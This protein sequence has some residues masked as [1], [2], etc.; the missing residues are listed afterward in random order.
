MV[1]MSAPFKHYVYIL[2]NYLII[3]E[4][5]LKQ[6]TFIF[7]FYRSSK[8]S[9]TVYFEIV[10]KTNWEERGYVE[11]GRKVCESYECR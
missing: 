8:F 1:V 6:M 10:D 7:A 3:I 9:N 11:K 4:I 5:N 2:Y